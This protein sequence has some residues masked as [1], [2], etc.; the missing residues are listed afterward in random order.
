M[1][2]NSTVLGQYSIWTVRYLDSTV[3][4]QYGIRTVRYFDSTVFGQ[5]GIRT[6][7]YLDSTV[8]GQYVIRSILVRKAYG[9]GTHSGTT[10]YAS[11]S[12][13][14]QNLRPIVD[15]C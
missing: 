6:V 11:H 14:S 13:T 2:S 1:Y 12:M 4:G 8:F 15:S 3:F 10:V 7:R 9:P 5:Y